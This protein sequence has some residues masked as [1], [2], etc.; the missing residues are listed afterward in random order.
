MTPGT[1]KSVL[2]AG[3]LILGLAVWVAVFRPLEPNPPFV[4]SFLRYEGSN[5]VIQIENKSRSDLVYITYFSLAFGAQ[6][7]SGLMKSH[8]SLE[9]AVRIFPAPTP[10]SAAAVNVSR[11]YV[12]CLRQPSETRLKIKRLLAWIGIR[13]IAKT[14]ETSIDL[15]PQ[16]PIGPFARVLA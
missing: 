13:S 11:I 6:Q 12:V 16:K 2:T 9:V 3:L 7:V 10:P 14:W 5:V 4:A 1:H 15:L 8:E